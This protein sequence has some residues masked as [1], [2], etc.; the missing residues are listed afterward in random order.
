MLKRFLISILKFLDRLSNDHV[1]ERSELRLPRYRK[2][3]RSIKPLNVYLLPDPK[4][5]VR[6]R[7]VKYIVQRVK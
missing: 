3:S 5:S 6:Q 2:K 4:T 1:F 7:L